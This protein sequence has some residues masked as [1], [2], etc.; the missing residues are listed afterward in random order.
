MKGGVNMKSLFLG[1]MALSLF[2]ACDTSRT[3]ITATIKLDSASTAD[4]KRVQYKGISADVQQIFEANIIGFHECVETKMKEEFDSV[5]VYAP[6]EVEFDYEKD[7]VSITSRADMGI[8]V[9]IINRNIGA[10]KNKGIYPIRNFYVGITNMCMSRNLLA[11]MR[12]L[13]ET[14]PDLAR[15]VL[16][17]HEI[18]TIYKN[19][20]DYWQ[21]EILC[22]SNNRCFVANPA[23][24]KMDGGKTAVSEGRTS[25]R[26]PYWFVIDNVKDM[27]GNYTDNYAALKF[28]E[29]QP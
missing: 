1:L 11:V 5:P 26:S 24:V 14:H 22:D 28:W 4:K 7:I 25:Q 19:D 2:S 13:F 23:L 27:S 16:K 8:V 10:I 29:I 17:R 3:N 6:I 18:H 12:G 9:P 20:K 21:E 15:Q